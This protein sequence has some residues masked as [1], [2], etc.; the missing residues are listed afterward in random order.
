MSSRPLPTKSPMPAMLQLELT[1]PRSRFT[2]AVRSRL[3]AFYE[4]SLLLVGVS[5]ESDAGRQRHLDEVLQALLLRKKGSAF[6]AV[7]DDVHSQVMEV[8]KKTWLDSALLE[9]Q[10]ALAA[11]R[12]RGDAP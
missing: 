6:H 4:T 8:A 10:T 5:S 1:A 2:E 7:M 3:T 12:F 11:E 9:I